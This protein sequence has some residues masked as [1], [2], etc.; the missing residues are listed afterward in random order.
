MNDLKKPTSDL[1]A[2][3]D[4]AR[5]VKLPATAPV[6]Q[7]SPPA[8]PVQSSVQKRSTVYVSLPF[9]FA[10]HET[11]YAAADAL[12]RK[13][14]CQ[15]EDIL[16][17]ISKRFDEQAINLHSATSP[18]RTG[19]SKRVLLKIAQNTIDRVRMMK[20]PLNIRSDGYLLRPPVIAALDRLAGTVLQ[21]LKEKYDV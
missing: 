16:L 15:I 7:P 6:T 8:P 13:I 20:D 9:T 17:L 21:E 4:I 18:A 11:H 3:F 19:P 12:A 10:L 5:S 1:K 2:K 14:G